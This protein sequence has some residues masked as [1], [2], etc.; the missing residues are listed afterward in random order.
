MCVS[1]EPSCVNSLGASGLAAALE[2]TGSNPEGL[3]SP[4]KETPGKTMET[5]IEQGFVF[6]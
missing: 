3:L 5:A 1:Q 4:R 6:K 2:E